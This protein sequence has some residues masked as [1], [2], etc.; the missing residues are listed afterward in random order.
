MAKV[1]RLG[2]SELLKIFT[3]SSVSIIAANKNYCKNVAETQ[4][5]EQHDQCEIRSAQDS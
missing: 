5:E 4:V 3:L 2:G 1:L